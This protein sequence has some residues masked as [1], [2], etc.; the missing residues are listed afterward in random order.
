MSH[1]NRGARPGAD[2]EAAVPAPIRVHDPVLPDRPGGAGNVVR[3]G[4][5][6]RV[7]RGRRADPRHLPRGGVATGGHHRGLAHRPDQR[8]L[9][10]REQEGEHQLLQLRHAV[11]CDRRRV[12]HH[13]DRRVP[14]GDDAD[15]G[16]PSGDRPA[17]PTTP[18]EGAM[19][20]PP[21]HGGVRARG[22]KLRDGGREPRVLRAGD[23]RDDRRR[24]RRDHR[25]RDRAPRMW[26]RDARV[27]DQ[28]VRDGDRVGV[29]GD[30]AQRRDRGTARDPGRGA[31]DRHLLRDAV[32]RSREGGSDPVSGVRHEGG[33]RETVPGRGARRRGRGAHRPAQGDPRGLRTC[34]PRDDVRRD[35]LG[36]PRASRSRRCGGGSRR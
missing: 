3:P 11:R 33:Q 2:E 8:P 15:R 5:H 6:V 17:R 35:P 25:S 22:H 9:R 26:D 24:V 19:D 28:P 31:G 16:D 30:P 34:V 10:D 13:R 27:D 20:D 18:W 7:E 32:R 23:H 21:P 4:R 12:V 36:R 14:R 1:D 29:R